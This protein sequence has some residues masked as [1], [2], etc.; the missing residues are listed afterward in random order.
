MKFI[1]MLCS[2]IRR[3]SFR[4]RRRN[5]KSLKIYS[6]IKY[7]SKEVK[8]FWIIYKIKYINFNN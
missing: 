8:Y 7:A 3:K 6:E 5:D 1:I 4:P 2:K